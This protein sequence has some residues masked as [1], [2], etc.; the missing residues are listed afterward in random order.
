MLLALYV[1]KLLDFSLRRKDHA[2]NKVGD[3]LLLVVIAVD[4]QK[5]RKVTV[6]IEHA[7]L[8]LRR[9]NNRLHR[10]TWK[11]WNDCT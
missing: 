9:H 10:H 11:V 2:L 3:Q 5:P 1:P 4:F 6:E 7:R 8:I